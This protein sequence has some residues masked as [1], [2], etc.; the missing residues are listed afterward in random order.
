MNRID[1]NF[2]P[3]CNNDEDCNCA[4]SMTIAPGSSSQ[5]LLFQNQTT[6]TT[7]CCC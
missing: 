7:L 3:S 1:M 6:F 4:F 5:N 2:E